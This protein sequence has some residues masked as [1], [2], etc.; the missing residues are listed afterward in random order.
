MKCEEARDHFSA[1]IEK[2]LDG[3]KVTAVRQH[4]SSCEGCSNEVG[5]MARVWTV[6]EREQ[7]V[8]KYVTLVKRTS[9]NDGYS[10]GRS[11]DQ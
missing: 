2:T 6:Q 7:Q 8:D 9:Q 1:Y 4:M 3:P 10:N 5:D 11:I